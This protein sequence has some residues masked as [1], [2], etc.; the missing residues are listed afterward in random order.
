MDRGSG[1]VRNGRKG[2]KNLRI[3][4]RRGKE[5]ETWQVDFVD[6]RTG[7]F[8]TKIS[9]LGEGCTNYQALVMKTP[10][11]GLGDG[12]V[13]PASHRALLPVVS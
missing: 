8:Q 6:A 13:L 2:E 9:S 1:E 12:A 4:P 7:H 10:S 3:F 11:P 5:G